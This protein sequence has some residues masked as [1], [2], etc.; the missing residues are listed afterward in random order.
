[1]SS[2]PLSIERTENPLRDQAYEVS[3]SVFFEAHYEDLRRI[4]ATRL[5]CERTRRTL[6]PT[7][8]VHETWLRLAGHRRAYVDA[9][10]FL[11][12]ASE[13]MRHVLVD[14][15]RSRNAL[16]RACEQYALPLEA[17]RNVGTKPTDDSDGCL[18]ELLRCLQEFN[19]RVARVLHLRFFLGLT[20]EETAAVLRVTRRT[21]N[22][23]WKFGKEWLYQRLTVRTAPL[24]HAA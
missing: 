21:V 6:S 17:V 22:R 4:A 15:A 3:D 5:R 7:A 16:R 20:E 18:R 19:P 24:R 9:S 2:F 10:Q 8:L 14:K 1:M 12:V 23:D 11:A 13:M